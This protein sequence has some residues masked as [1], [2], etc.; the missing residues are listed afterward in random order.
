MAEPGFE[1]GQPNAR[2]H[3]FNHYTLLSAASK[4]IIKNGSD[5]TSMSMKALKSKIPER[6]LDTL[7][8]F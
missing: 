8:E 1:L 6:H 2:S 4:E 5:R 3:A 7:N